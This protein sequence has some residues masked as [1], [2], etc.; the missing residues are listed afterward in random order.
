MVLTWYVATFARQPRHST[1]QHIVLL[2]LLLFLYILYGA[3][4]YS[5]R[6]V[7][8]QLVSGSLQKNLSCHAKIIIIMEV[9]YVFYMHGCTV[10]L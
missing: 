4:L 6:F 10:L 3:L 1:A 9:V 8:V 2:L 5:R 7:I